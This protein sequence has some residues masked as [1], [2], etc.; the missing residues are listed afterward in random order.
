MLR[1]NRD[2]Q[3]LRYS[4]RVVYH[5]L[6]TPLHI[7]RKRMPGLSGCER[8]MREVEF[9][10]PIP[11]HPDRRPPP[12]PWQGDRQDRIRLERG[13]IK[14]FIDLIFEFQGRVYLVDWKSDIL[15]DYSA[16]AVARHVY[17]EYQLQAQ[18]YTI[19]LAR[20]LEIETE[21]AHR[22]RFGGLLYCFM[23][24]MGRP[25]DAEGRQPAVFYVRPTLDK[26]VELTTDLA[27]RD[28]YR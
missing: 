19:A 4:Q 7:G 27:N 9:L 13:Y 21:N 3:H 23:R 11:T 14:G 24:G 26:L 18:L 10:Y 22:R 28:D 8:I 16:R 6:T 15:A 17:R 25:M 20:M 1:F 2:P 5:C 12:G